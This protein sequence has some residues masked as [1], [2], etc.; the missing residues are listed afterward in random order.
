MFKQFK[1]LLVVMMR[2]IRAQ[3]ILFFIQN[4]AIRTL[5][6]KVQIE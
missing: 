5:I 2:T 3:A 1:T 4:N 6:F